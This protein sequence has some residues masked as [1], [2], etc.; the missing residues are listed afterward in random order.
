M[1]ELAVGRPDLAIREGCIISVSVEIVSRI[2]ETHYEEH[3][4]GYV[5]YVCDR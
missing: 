1:F 3:D 5:Q 2:L 4:V